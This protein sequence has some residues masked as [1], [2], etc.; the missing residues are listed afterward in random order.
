MPK[1]GARGQNALLRAL[2]A[3]AIQHQPPSQP[4]SRGRRN[5]R[6]RAR[7][8]GANMAS[9][10]TSIPAGFTSQPTPRRPR[11]ATTA[12]GMRVTHEE[13]F[14]DL[15]PES[16]GVRFKEWEMGKT[17]CTLLD[18]LAK[19]YSRYTLHSMQ[20]IYRPACGTGT[21]GLFIM[22]VDWDASDAPVV[23]KI[24]TMSPC[25]RG[26]AW[27]PASMTLPVRQ[28]QQYSNRAYKDK[29]FS[30]PFSVPKTT[31]A[32]WGELSVKYDIS[33]YGPSGN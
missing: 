33:F 13:F 23:G 25:H 31:T 27:Q 6:R 15:T 1:R 5:R 3:L 7:R 18:S 30:I 16:G 2:Q 10:A 32:I 28:L 8:S 12:D 22:A 17:G 20:V 9:A 19:A 29:P 21:D 14:T 26:P 11:V 4:T 24:R